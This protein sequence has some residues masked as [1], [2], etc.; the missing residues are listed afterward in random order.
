M[1]AATYTLLFA[2]PRRAFDAL[3]AP[4]YFHKRTATNF[5][6][7]IWYWRSGSKSGPIF[8][9]SFKWRQYPES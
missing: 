6:T 9:L 3:N 7:I 5:G 2:R 1:N 8:W 4:D